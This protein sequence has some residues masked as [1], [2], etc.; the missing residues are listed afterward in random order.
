LRLYERKIWKEGDS[1][2]NGDVGP[3]LEGGDCGGG[4]VQPIAG[5]GVRSKSGCGGRAS[6]RGGVLGV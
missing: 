3:A 4:W 1:Q 2:V 5:T 6:V